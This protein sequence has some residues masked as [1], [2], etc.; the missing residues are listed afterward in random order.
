LIFMSFSGTLFRLEKEGRLQGR[1]Q[2]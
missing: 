2:G 1:F